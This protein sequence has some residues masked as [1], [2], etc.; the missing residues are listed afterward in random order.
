M[1]LA[2]YVLVMVAAVAFIA[3]PFAYHFKSRGAWRRHAL[4]W[5]LMTYMA[6][7]ALAMVVTV[8]N[9]VS[10]IA[11]RHPLPAWIG[12]PLWALIAFVAW[13]R[14]AIILHTKRAEQE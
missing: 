11:W 13:W 5:H 14:L 7:F 3:S 9:V 1:R 6:A 4:G 12:P 10:I 8:A 2:G